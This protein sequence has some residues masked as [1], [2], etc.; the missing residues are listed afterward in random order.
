[1]VQIQA[2]ARASLDVF[3]PTYSEQVRHSA[4]R[5]CCFCMCFTC[6]FGLV[7]GVLRA[8]LERQDGKPQGQHPTSH[9]D[10]ARYF[11]TIMFDVAL[12]PS[13]VVFRFELCALSL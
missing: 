7:V 4:P 12:R 13:M 10:L 1:M 11:C 9:H 2:I 8:S 3:L 6:V 5:P